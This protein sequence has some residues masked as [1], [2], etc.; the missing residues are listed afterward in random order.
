M[1]GHGPPAREHAFK[2]LGFAE[3]LAVWAARAWVASH[4]GK[5][6]LTRTIRET[7]TAAGVVGG[8]ETLDRTMRRVTRGAR[9]PIDVRCG[10]CRT[11]SE[12]ERLFL[13]VLHL[14]Q[15]DG[16]PT[17]EVLSNLR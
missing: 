12:D 16:G 9:R 10:H 6:E 14:G 8:F 2:D 3:K 5:P 17:S 11:V 1:A 13:E 15:R 7:L 4:K